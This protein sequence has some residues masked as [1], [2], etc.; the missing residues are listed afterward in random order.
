MV[1]TATVTD[2]EFGS[3]LPQGSLSYGTTAITF[4]LAP[5]VYR[6]CLTAP[7]DPSTIRYQSNDFPGGAAGSDL[8]FIAYDEGERTTSDLTLSIIGTSAAILNEAGADARVRAIQAVDDGL[9]RNVFRNDETTPL[10]PAPLAAGVL[11]DY[12]S[13]SSPAFSDLKLVPIGGG[14]PE[15]SISLAPLS[16][17]AYTVVYAGD[18]TDGINAT[19][20]AEDTRPFVGQASAR[21]IHAAGMH[22]TVEIFVR[23]PGTDLTNSIPN[24]G[25]SSAPGVSPRFP[26]VPGD[27]EITVRDILTKAVLAG[28]V[29]VTLEDGGVYGVMT[30]NNPADPATVTIQYIYDLAP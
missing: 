14:D 19:L 4:S 9:D 20:M 16:S 28:P 6:L 5:A 23:P 30:L 27:Y 18:T 11:S 3:A 15:A 12:A 1:D 24:A 17:H 8:A 21:F 13:V 26:F 29:P 25:F 2:C 10:Y 7:G 22:D